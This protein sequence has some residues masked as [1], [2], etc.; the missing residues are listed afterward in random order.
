MRRRLDLAAS[1]IVKPKVLFLDEPTTGL[2]PR[3]RQEMWSV[4]EE[5]VKG[6]VTL[7]LTTQ[8]LEEADQLADEIA[9]IDHG[10][11][12]AR[13]TSDALKKQVGGERLEIVV[14][15]Q[16][17]AKAM[18]VVATVSGNKA[19]LDEG[20]R[21]I[22]APVSTGATALIETL[23]SLDAAGIHPLDVGLKRPS[24]DDVFLS[25]TGHAAEEKV[26]EPEVTGRRKKA[27]K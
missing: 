11:V 23:R 17:I 19:S 15:S 20:L 2:D 26:E 25:L 3:G 8:Y 14:E 6:G 5:L 24:L 7:L 21:M 16:N 13:G 22:S 27:K 18:E 12:I 1:L 4:I 10:K 9:V